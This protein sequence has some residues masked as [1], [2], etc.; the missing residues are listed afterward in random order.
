MLGFGK[1]LLVLGY[2]VL[3]GL[4]V[5]SPATF[6]FVF[7]TGKTVEDMASIAVFEAF[8]FVAVELDRLQNFGGA[9]TILDFFH[10]HLG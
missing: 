9:T 10:S 2:A 1:V 3:S 5:H 4:Q 8:D 7:F 6:P